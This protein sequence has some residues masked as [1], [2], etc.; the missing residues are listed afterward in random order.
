MSAP[1]SKLPFNYSMK[2]VGARFDD[3]ALLA[4]LH[5]TI[6]VGTCTCDAQADHATSAEQVDDTSQIALL[7]L[8]SR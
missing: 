1:P 7:A 6:E 4:G 5:V 8:L 2:G 3:D